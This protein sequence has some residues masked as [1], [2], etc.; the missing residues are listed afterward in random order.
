MA[1]STSP[2][3]IGTEY[4]LPALAAAVVKDGEVIASGAA[5]TRVYGADIPVTI[6]D[7]SGLGSNTKAM[8][9][10]PAGMVV[11]EGKPRWDSS[12]GEV[13]G[14]GDCGNQPGGCGGDSG[15]AAVALQ[16]HPDGH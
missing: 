1:R 15:A 13:L 4:T 14:T 3:R 5:G 7:R 6:D 11:G 9:A 16:R 10:R 2:E 8:T 12:L